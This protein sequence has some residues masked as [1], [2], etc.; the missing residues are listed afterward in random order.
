[1]KHQKNEKQ[2]EGYSVYLN[3]QAIPVSK[4]VYE[5]Y[6]RDIWKVYKIMRRRGLCAQSNWQRCGGDCGYCN[7]QLGEY[8]VSLELLLENSDF[9]IGVPDSNPGDIIECKMFLEKA[10][11]SADQIVPGGKRILELFSEGNTDRDIADILS[12]PHSTFSKRK[13]K[14]FR[15]LRKIF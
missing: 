5:E 1:M 2:N 3:G 14:L 10:L 13:L 4:E 9:E 8:N 11:N 12:I 6:Y 15:E 7:Y